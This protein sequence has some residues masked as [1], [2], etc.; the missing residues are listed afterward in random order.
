VK[1][2]SPSHSAPAPHRMVKPLWHIFCRQ[3]RKGV[4]PPTRNRQT[5]L[6]CFPIS[7]ICDGVHPITFQGSGCAQVITGSLRGGVGEGATI[8]SPLGEGGHQVGSHRT[9]HPHTRHTPTASGQPS[10]QAQPPG[11]RTAAQARS[12]PPARCCP[13][14]STHS[15]RH[16]PSSSA[17]HRL[18][19]DTAGADCTQYCTCEQ[20]LTPA[21]STNDFVI[22]RNY[23]QL[24]L[25]QLKLYV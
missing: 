3:R 22:R 6:R 1:P 7:A 16:S 11:R 4:L 5:S 14:D 8:G 20:L 17:T 12:V 23:K 25:R 18:N 21:A 10:A 24:A 9:A 2:R 15:A 19:T 13:S